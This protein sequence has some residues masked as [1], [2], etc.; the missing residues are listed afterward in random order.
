[1]N[2]QLI[3][4]NCRFSHSCLALFYVRN[5]LEKFPGFTPEIRQFSLNDPY[6]S[7]LLTISGSEPKALFFSVYI[8]NSDY[9]GRLV[10]DLHRI[11][12]DTP[13]VMGGPQAE[14][15][16]QTLSLRPTVIHGPIEGLDTTFYDDLR[17]RHLKEDYMADHQV[18]FASPYKQDDFSRQLKNRNIYYES[19]RGC[20]FSCTYCLS[21]VEHGL[22]WRD[23]AAVRQELNDILRHSPKIIRFVDRTFNADRQRAMAVWRFLASQAGA[24]TFHFEIA[25]DLF[26]EDML[27][28]LSQLPVGL[29]QFEIGIQSTHPPT[30]RAVNRR[31]NITLARKNIKR[32]LSFK[33]IHLH[34]DLILGLPH[35]TRQTFAQSLRDVFALQPHYIQMGLLKVLPDTAICHN[36]SSFG[37]L[38]TNR[39]PYEVMATD[40]LKHSDIRHLF[41]LSECVEAFYNNRFFRSFFACLHQQDVDIF[42]FF[43]ELL[44][45][46]R[47]NDFFTLAKTQKLLNDIL[48]QLSVC[49]S[50]T[51]LYRELLIYDWLRCGHHFL[52]DSLPGDL[53]KIKDHLWH[54]LPDEIPGI[55][56]L[57]QRHT[58]FKRTIFYKFSADLLNTVGL[59]KSRKDD[60]GYLAFLAEAS[61]IF[62]LRKAI[63]LPC[64]QRKSGCQ[65]K[66]VD[67]MGE[68]P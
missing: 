15:L 56:N 11:M 61:G 39:P 38:N 16:R 67:D 31:M 34:I 62:A 54:I 10:E 53:K 46:C 30:L 35:D 32:L 66:F 60:D 28:F 19:V 17:Q 33:N 41:W 20:P 63:L 26:D 59:R 36:R 5:E 9:T 52:P 57:R 37:I 6:Y 45:I 12:P 21:S 64:C 68:K 8:W 23:I 2:I 40:W 44:E 51:N 18:P 25:P 3:A 50:Q 42:L 48:L 13:I 49:R 7:T 29:F 4:I 43:A 27:D 22:V 24:T 65:H 58:F 55:F 14:T 1:M 47:N